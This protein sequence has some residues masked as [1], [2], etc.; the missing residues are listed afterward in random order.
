M[1]VI[2]PEPNARLAPVW[3]RVGLLPWFIVALAVVTAAV[4]PRFLTGMNLTNVLRNSAFLLLVSA[5]QMFVIVG[6]GFDLSVGAVVALASVVCALV[7]AAVGAYLPDSAGLAIAAGIFAGLGVGVLVGLFNS[8]C[9]Q[10]LRASGFM[11]TLGAMSI[12]SGLAFYLTAGTPIYGLPAEFTH[13]FGRAML[14]G[15]PLPVWIALAILA[16]AWMLQR[17]TATGR[18][19]YAVGGNASAARMSGIPV[20][21]HVIGIY[22]ACALLAAL[23]GVLLTARLGSGQATLGSDLMLQSIAACMIAGVRLTG[24]VGRIEN[25]ALG[26]LFLSTLGNSMNL[27]R[28]DGKAQTV[29][30]GLII[31]VAV[32]VEQIQ[33]RRKSHED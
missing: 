5:G 28:I 19:L 25:V 30:V 3:R 27:L 20:A 12:V 33:R 24:G 1:S 2:A 15:L 13:A 11:V 29:V 17:R 26:A 8:V 6:A 21:P 18:H 23:T 32:A 9:V 7:M 10:F 14:L 4:E 31:I 16:M 22:V